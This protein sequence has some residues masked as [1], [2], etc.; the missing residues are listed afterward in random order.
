MAVLL[1]ASNAVTVTVNAAPAVAFAGALT[2]K[3]VAG[4]G[5][6]VS[7]AAVVVAGEP[8]PL[9]NTARY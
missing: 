2:V 3:C 1:K 9:V 4:P 8:T 5:F 6:T 7:V